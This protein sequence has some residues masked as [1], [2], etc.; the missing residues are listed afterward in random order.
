M[1]RKKY[2]TNPNA[3]IP[4]KKRPRPVVWAS[5]DGQHRLEQLT[6]P[7]HL[8]IE[9]RA[10]QHCIHTRMVH[11]VGFPPISNDV[12]HADQL[13]YW[14][15][16]KKGHSI[17]SLVGVKGPLVTIH[18]GMTLG[19][20]QF[21]E[22]NGKRN[23]RINGTEPY[24]PT[25]VDALT[26]IEG[27]H[28]HPLRRPLDFGCPKPMRKSFARR[29][30]TLVGYLIDVAVDIEVAV[31][32]DCQINLANYILE[33]AEAVTPAQLVDVIINR[34]PPFDTLTLLPEHESRL[35]C[36][37]LRMDIIHRTYTQATPGDT[38]IIQA[39]PPLPPPLVTTRDLPKFRPA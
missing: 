6:H 39:L 14:S 25:L 35:I 32:P 8:L 3:D 10:M 21:L 2:E 1:P 4:L 28:G 31:F 17:Y 19:L 24:F 36:T 34:R 30:D 23:H 27:L 29:M 9:G 15:L 18:V 33:I 22:I 37:L 16:I 38:R 20:A 11:Q 12:P 26:H 7:H 5:G 13:Y